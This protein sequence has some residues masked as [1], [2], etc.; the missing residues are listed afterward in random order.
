[1]YRYILCV[2]MNY[3]E[4]KDSIEIGGHTYNKRDDLDSLTQQP[5]YT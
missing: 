2:G 5:K 1:M 3:Q 4:K